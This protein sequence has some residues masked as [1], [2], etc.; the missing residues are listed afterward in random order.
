MTILVEIRRQVKN[1]KC[2]I[3]NYVE[4]NKIVIEEAI[5]LIQQVQKW[6][7]LRKDEK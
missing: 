1:Q 6:L 3:Q 4:S 2:F 7:T 5:D